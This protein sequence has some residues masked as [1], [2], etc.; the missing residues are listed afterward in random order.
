MVYCWSILGYLG[1]FFPQN[2]KDFSHLWRAYFFSD[3]IQQFAP[4]K[5]FVLP[6]APVDRPSYLRH[7]L[8]D[9]TD[10]KKYS[11]KIFLSKLRKI[12]ENAEIIIYFERTLFIVH[13]HV[14]NPNI[15][16]SQSSPLLDFPPEKNIKLIWYQVFKSSRFKLRSA[17]FW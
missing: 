17:L 14:N 16:R 7:W 15:S 9:I 11:F 6:Y 3:E 10:S 2:L 1:Q 8:D 5:I 13:L 12:K 4:L